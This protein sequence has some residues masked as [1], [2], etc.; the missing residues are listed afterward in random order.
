MSHAN[1]D[2]VHFNAVV[3]NEVGV[4]NALK[5]LQLISYQFDCLHVVRLEPQLQEYKGTNS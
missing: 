5:C 3:F 2:L 1:T 4:I